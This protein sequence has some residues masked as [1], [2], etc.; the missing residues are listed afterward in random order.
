MRQRTRQSKRGQTRKISKRPALAAR[1]EQLEERLLLSADLIGVHRPV[2]DAGYFIQEYNGNGY[3]DDGDRFFEF[4]YGTDTPLI[5]DWNGDG[6]D[7]IGV[8][9]GVGNAGYFIQDYNGNGYWDGGDRF[10][11]FG[12][13]TDTPLIGDWNGDGTDQIGVHREVGAAG[14][15]IQEYNGNGYWDGG[16]RYFEFGYATDTPLIGD[17]NGDGADQIG[18]HREVGAAGYFIQEYNGNGY[19]DGGDRY[20]EFGYATDTPLIGDWN[21]DGAGQIG[22]HREVGAAG[23]FI[24]EYNGNGYWDG[25][26]RYFEFGYATDTPLIAHWGSPPVDFQDPEL[27]EAVRDSLGLSAGEPITRRNLLDLTSLT[28]DSNQVES[29]VGLEYARELQQ[30]QLRPS[31]WSA[32]YVGLSGPSP[33]GP[34]AGLTE[35]EELALVRV[36][37]AGPELESLAELDNLGTLDLRYNSIGTFPDLSSFVGLHSL[38]VHGNPLSDVSSL[39]GSPIHVDLVAQ[40]SQ[41]AVTPAELAEALNYLPV[42]MFAYLYNNFE[43]QPYDGLM[44]GARATLETRAGNDW[45]LA[46]LLI[47]MLGEAG[48]TGQYVTG[49]IDVS[50]DLVTSWVG[51]DD[52][53]EAARI[54]NAAYQNAEVLPDGS[55]RCNHT[56][57]EAWLQVPG[58]GAQWVAMDPSFKL[59]DYSEGIPGILD[60][61]PFDEADYLQE[62]RSELPHE[63]YERQL[64]EYLAEN[65]PGASV[66]DVGY[67]GPI[68]QQGFTAIPATL[69][70]AVSQTTARFAANG[71]P[72]DWKHRA[73]VRV[74]KEFNPTLIDE[75]FAIPDISLDRLTVTYRPESPSSDNLIPELRLDGALLASGSSTVLEG[76]TTQVIVDPLP[77]QGRQ[78]TQVKKPS[79]AGEPLAVGFHAMQFSDRMLARQTQALIDATVVDQNGLLVDSSEVMQQSLF[80]ALANYYRSNLTA[81]EAIGDLVHLV[82]VHANIDVGFTT[83]DTEFWDAEPDTQAVDLFW[84]LPFPAVPKN[85]IID[86]KGHNTQSMLVGDAVYEA[87]VRR[88]VGFTN[89]AQEHAVWERLF[90]SPSISTIKL[91]QLASEAPDNSIVYDNGMAV[92]PAD[93]VEYGAWKW[94]GEIAEANGTYDY[95]IWPVSPVSNPTFSGGLTSWNALAADLIAGLFPDTKA[96][97]PVRINTG[98]FD[99]QDTDIVLPAAGF[100]LELTRSYRSLSDIDTGFGPGWTHSYSDTIEEF[101]DVASIGEGTGDWIYPVP[102]AYKTARTQT[103][104][105]QDEV[106]GSRTITGLDLDVTGLPGRALS[107]WTIRMKHTSMNEYATAAWEANDGSWTTVYRTDETIAST[108]W[109]HFEFDTPFSYNGLDNLMLDFSYR[110]ESDASRSGAVAYSNVSGNRALYKASDNDL[111]DPLQWSG[112]SPSPNDSIRLPNI[113]LTSQGLKWTDDDGTSFVFGGNETSG[114]TTPPELDGSLTVRTDGY[115]FRDKTGQ[116]HEFDLDGGLAEL[117]DRN[118]NALAISRD[119]EGRIQQVVDTD[120]PHRRLDFSWDGNHISQ[121][122]AHDNDRQRVWAYDYTGDTLQVT[123]PS[124]EEA[125]AA[126]TSY[127]YYAVDDPVLGGLVHEIVAP[128]GGTTTIDH[129]SNRQVFRVTDA[130]ERSEHFYYDLYRDRTEYVDACGHSTLY[131]YDLQGYTTQIVYPNRARESYTWEEGVMTS[132]TDPFGHSER[133]E[134]YDDGLGNLRRLIDRTGLETSFSDYDAFGNARRIERPGGRATTFAYDAGGNRISTEDALGNVTSMT[135]DGRGLVQTV[136]RPKGN[137]TPTDGDY[138]TSFTYN[139]AGQVLT[140]TTDLPSQWKYSYDAFGN[141]QTATDPNDNTTTYDYDALDRLIRFEDPLLHAQTLSYDPAGRLLA[142]TDALGY[143][144]GFTYDLTGNLLRTTHPD[145]TYWTTAHDPAGNSV[146]TTD[147]AGQATRLV[148]DT[149]HQPIQTI[150]ADGATTRTR[151]DGGQR[152]VAVIDPRGNQSYRAYDE[153]DRLLGVADEAGNAVVYQYEAVT[154]DLEFVVDRRG[155]VT[156]YDYDPLGRVVA[157]FGAGGFVTAIEYDANGM[158]ARTIRYDVKGLPSVPEDLSTLPAERQQVYETQYDVLDRPIR[159][160]DPSGESTETVYDATGRVTQT[161]DERGVAILFDYDAAGR[162]DSRTNPDGGVVDFGYDAADRLVELTM[163]EGGQWRWEYDSRSRVTAETDPLDRQT[164]YRHAA[165]DAVL[166]QTNPDGSWIDFRYDEVWRLVERVRSDGSFDRYTYD[167]NGNVVQAE[168]QDTRL[169]LSYDE[170]DRTATEQTTIFGDAFESLVRYDYDA[171]G[172]LVQIVDPWDRIID[173][174]Y[175][176]AGRLEAL[177]G[178][179]GDSVQITYTGFGQ[180][181]TVAFGNGRI[182]TFAYDDRGDLARIDYSGAGAASWIEYTARDDAGAPI[183]INEDLDGATETLTITRD[184]MGRPDLVTAS[185]DSARSEDFSY[186]LDGNLVD[187]GVFTGSQFDEA[188]QLLSNSNATYEHDAQGNLTVTHNADGSRIETRHDPSNRIVVVRQYDADGGLLREAEFIYDALGRRIKIVDGE[189][190]E[191]RVF[192]FQNTIAT[193][194]QEGGGPA[195]VKQYLVGPG[196]D[197]VFGVRVDGVQR[198]VHRDEIG[199][200]RLV[201]DT[202]GNVI[203]ANDYSLFGSP[204]SSTG[205]NDTG[206]G[207]TARPVDS[208]TGLVDL[209]ARVYNPSTAA[210]LERDPLSSLPRGLSLQSYCADRPL[211]MVD[212]TGLSPQKPFY[213]VPTN[214]Q[215]QVVAQ[216]P[217][218][219]GQESQ[220]HNLGTHPINCVATAA[221]AVADRPWWGHPLGYDPTFGD[222][223]YGNSTVDDLNAASEVILDSYANLDALFIDQLG[224]VRVRISQFDMANPHNLQLVVVYESTLFGIPT[225]VAHNTENESW[226]SQL[227]AGGSRFEHPDYDDLELW[228][229]SDVKYVYVFPRTTSGKPVDPS[230]LP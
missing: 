145:G 177:D 162:L 77:P 64:T 90:N 19:W 176:L 167:P 133:Y 171:E 21:G 194:V 151:Y 97:D 191:R 155:A 163:P 28:A 157:T 216:Y 24:Q 204:V 117:R 173:C 72:D 42:E 148:Y 111:G 166:G 113:R 81:I 129:Y 60:L 85:L 73:R 139:D 61:V 138:T 179:S 3:W 8:H 49:V 6:V 13:A 178:S 156:S 226:V 123:S 142:T 127:N 57:V 210:Y 141:L 18:V 122:V 15:F 212:P 2:G 10:Y 29:L 180:R 47:D 98:E 209:R 87:A 143:T 164:E 195:K 165:V 116:V 94:D 186:D 205:N 93:D 187:T 23:Y 207:F 27:A 221:E 197:D 218:L 32:Q 25:G 146:A 182:D 219:N 211:A 45:D 118:G 83:C 188:D 107:D 11:Q 20:F 154:G 192:A 53:A 44:K 189:T 52:A 152:V 80:V 34:L 62:V 102:T 31:N 66:V 120:A 124:D 5:G 84:D 222:H 144:T 74:T 43:Y 153:A 200:V 170:L 82:P 76:S 112:T 174:G 4:G 168:N 201:T 88:L 115:T 140:K 50:V 103:I 132:W 135:Y 65:M 95:S 158:I 206:L 99:R 184:T 79:V 9:R 92:R 228:G 137:L 150:Y 59:K 190:T 136:T 16:D 70:Y 54:L 33:L 55:V 175:D 12:Y 128:D 202:S 131:D 147:E 106:G 35:L 199:S 22:V 223:Y 196:L 110:N 36:G 46:G 169:I 114:Y 119:A 91:L 37:L 161:I 108:G 38:N 100:P 41:A 67:D 126:V 125:P 159:H 56:W 109:T 101:N 14:Y 69:P 17:W 89:S 7:E 40:S 225:H 48:V 217:R 105:L 30:L 214:F 58:S 51:G 149:R 229:V 220:I 86:L 230:R 68:I 185:I 63:Y 183:T 78:S 71:V 104:Y 215:Q 26:D 213:Y 121:V 227:G 160:I 198:Y 130:E 203:A 96:G 224:G 75:T 1:I 172:N 208:G 193:V 134:Y 39:A 181:E